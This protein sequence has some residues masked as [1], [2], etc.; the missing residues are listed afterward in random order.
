MVQLAV[1]TAVVLTRVAAYAV[2]MNVMV[3]V[4]CTVTGFGMT[5]FVAGAVTA[6]TVYVVVAFTVLVTT[7]VEVIVEALKHKPGRRTQLLF[8][9]TYSHEVW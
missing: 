4:E 7:I 5:V 3:F 2:R 9:R 1:T 8:E 6:G